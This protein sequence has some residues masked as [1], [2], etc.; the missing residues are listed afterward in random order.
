MINDGG[1]AITNDR[2]R[3]KRTTKPNAT[4]VLIHT[5]IITSYSRQPLALRPRLLGAAL[6]T[7]MVAGRIAISTNEFSERRFNMFSR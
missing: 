7:V 3:L 6:S 5:A 1:N 2:P 4:I